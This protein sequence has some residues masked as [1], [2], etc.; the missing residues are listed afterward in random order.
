[1]ILHHALWWLDLQHIIVF[2][3]KRTIHL[4]IH[5]RLLR[6]YDKLRQDRSGGW[7]EIYVQKRKTTNATWPLP[8]QQQAAAGSHFSSGTVDTCRVSRNK[9]AHLKVSPGRITWRKGWCY[10]ICPGAM[11]SS[12]ITLKTCSSLELKSVNQ[13]SL[14]GRVNETACVVVG[15]SRCE[16]YSPPHE[17]HLAAVSRVKRRISRS[18]GWMRNGF[19]LIWRVVCSQ[20]CLQ[21]KTRSHP[22]MVGDMSRVT[23]NFDLT[24]IPFVHF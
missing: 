7:R 18:S 16:W 23:L 20:I 9:I 17:S 21:G 3:T 14:N 11:R 8:Q 5:I 1:M 13:Q 2:H 15:V 4:F 22:E 24:K 10:F 12:Q 19:I 6:W